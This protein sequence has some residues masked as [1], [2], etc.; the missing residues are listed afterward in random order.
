MA[1]RKDPKRASAG[2]FADDM[3][4]NVADYRTFSGTA[5]ERDRDVTRP[6][7]ISENTDLRRSSVPEE[8]GYGSYSDRMSISDGQFDWQ[9][10][11][12]NDV[13]GASTDA[14][15][16]NFEQFAGL[17]QDVI[18]QAVVFIEDAYKYRS[19]CHRVDPKIL[20]FY[21]SYLSTWVNIIHV[22]VIA[23]LHL[24][25]F[26]EYPSSL[27]W[28]SDI[29]D[30]GERI[31]LPC[32]VT[33][34]IEL[35]CLLLLLAD[36]FIRSYFMGWSYF[37][38]HRWL[39][40]SVFILSMSLV[41][42]M[43]SVTLGC[44]E[45][46]RFRRILRPFF[47]LQN[48]S[49]MKKTINCLRRTLPEVASVLLLLFL[50]LFMFTLFGMLLF[51]KATDT[52][53]SDDIITNNTN[54][55]QTSDTSIA[56]TEGQE[57][58]KTLLQAFM[59]LLVL[60]TTA[61]NPDV[62]MPAYRQNRFFAMFFI[63]FLGI[64]L[65]CFMNMLTAVIYNRFRGY[66]LNS[67]QGSHFRRKL[68]VRAAFEILRRRKSAFRH[69]SSISTISVGVGHS[70]VKSIVDQ[71]NVSKNVKKALQQA[72]KRRQ[73]AIYAATDFQTL[74]E[75]LNQEEAV[76][77]RPEIRWFSDYPKIVA[78]QKILIHRYF[79]YFECSM[80]FIN[81]ILISVQLQ[82]QYDR[83]LTSS[84]STLRVINFCF[85]IYYVIEQCLKLW[86]MGWRRYV[87]ERE[88]IFEAVITIALA[89]GETV[90][91]IEY[92]IPVYGN[93]IHGKLMLW[94]IIRIINI[95]I[96]IRLLRVIPHIQAMSIIA[97]TIIDLVKN[98]KAFAGI[99]IVFYYSFAIMGMELFHD[100]IKYH[101]NS[102]QNGSVLP[103]ECGSYQQLDYWANN[104]DDFAASVV[105]L[106]DIMVV[107]N[108][109]VFL[110]AYAKA[111]SYWSYIYFI[112]WW[113]LSVVIVLN[114]FTALI[115]ENFI[116]KWDKNVLASRERSGTAELEE[117]NNLISLHQ[118]F[119]DSLKEPAENEL[120]VELTNHNYLMLDR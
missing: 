59:S 114:L 85:I 90:N 4:S 49:L 3:N 82:L 44:Q 42:W 38:G 35:I 87:S 46:I 40:V 60:L 54:P 9:L 115:L 31:T 75:E 11:S 24:L 39:V 109:H 30:R 73:P 103:Y 41:D 84:H 61:N 66:F 53:S 80:A 63:I 88:H 83:S 7:R 5:D 107:N 10:T 32:G 14:G 8:G 13:L 93:N 112:I 28:T 72:L 67:M 68:G 37:K 71:I 29:R 25:A 100:A 96:M 23:V 55:N 45:Y 15:S 51:P 56:S 116:I 62:M 20:R 99:L 18:F 19:I 52:D 105:V 6:L 101:G 43:V 12:N 81:V 36:T 74:F 91:A 117:A 47:I 64:G 118:M 95:L 48:S 102:T 16:G 106:W 65:Y 22:T 1:K 89:I 77:E 78:I 50:H 26:L 33:E 79:F 97:S 92:G 69:Q 108:W 98:M 76:R 27:T 111:T 94:N 2:S 57:Y 113:L 119:R 34:S 58:F 70:V 21:R 17:D 86:A 120:L 104:F 110:A